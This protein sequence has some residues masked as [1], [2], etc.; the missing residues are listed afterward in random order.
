MASRLR[1]SSELDR[2]ESAACVCSVSIWE[3]MFS[4]P[5]VI[6]G[7]N[8]TQGCG[9]TVQ[10]EV[11]IAKQRQ[12]ELQRSTGHGAKPSGLFVD[13][14]PDAAIW[15]NCRSGVFADLRRDLSRV[16]FF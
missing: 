14:S 5:H 6:A 15:Q 13:A 3:N 9:D 7:K 12:L 8:L 11:G 16:R 1:A 4:L 2:Y 10:I